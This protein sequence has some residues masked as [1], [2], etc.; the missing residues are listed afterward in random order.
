M[1]VSPMTAERRHGHDPVHAFASAARSLASRLATSPDLSDAIPNALWLFTAALWQRAL[2]F[3]PEYALWPDRDRFVVSSP[4]LLP[5]R[6]AFLQ[7][8]GWKDELSA[9]GELHGLAG[10]LPGQAVASAAGMALAEKIL[11]RRFGHSLVNHRTWLIALPGDLHT[12]VALETAVLAG[13]F[14]LERLTVVAAAS[15]TRNTERQSGDEDIGQIA[16]SFESSGWSVRRINTEDPA[17]IISALTA[18]QRSRKPSLILCESNAKA[19]EPSKTAIDVTAWDPTKR[20]GRAA[21]R[22]WLRRLGHHA[23]RAEFERIISGRPIPGLNDDF[24]RNWMMTR[25][26]AEPHGSAQPIISAGLHGRDIF[27][28]LMPEFITLR[29]GEPAQ[30]PTGRKNTASISKTNRPATAGFYVCGPREPA[31]VGLMNGLALHGGLIPCGI[32]PLHSIDRMRP[33]LRFA[34]LARQRLICLLTESDPDLGGGMWQQ[35]EQLAS[36]RAMP[37]LALFRPASI[38][39]AAAAWSCALVWQGGPSVIVLGRQP[40]S[41]ISMMNQSLSETGIPETGVTDGPD[42]RTGLSR[43]GYVLEH[44]SADNEKRDVTL[45]ASGPEILIAKRAK[46][47]LDEDGLRVAL[48]SLPCWELFTRQDQAYRD[49]VLGKAPRVAIEAASGFGWERWLGS[50]GVFIG[51]DEFGLAAGFGALYHN[52]GITPEAIR[53]RAHKL[54]RTARKAADPHGG[55]HH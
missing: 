40:A 30:F 46:E 37:N 15:V 47:L 21:R 10:G 49:F 39:E 19:P 4:R 6:Q 43:G 25:A 9:A 23:Q 41:L 16:G 27:S 29:S 53:E 32:A 45:I 31:M 13:R 36:L 8:A 11:S 38:H 5:L 50:K 3:D 35:V 12:G 20:K 44:S 33:A 34:A 42:M 24:F 55:L 17:A 1:T 2:R 28:A 52:S 14:G 26:T 54:L 51:R 18:S 48:V 7:L 22:A